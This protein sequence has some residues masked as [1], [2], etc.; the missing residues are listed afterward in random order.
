MMHPLLMSVALISSVA[1][2]ATPIVIDG[3]FDDWP[4]VAANELAVAEDGRFVYVHL[5]APGSPSN[6]QGLASPD[7][8]R[9][10][11]DHDEGTGA[12]SG[13]YRGTDLELH[14][15]PKTGRRS[16]GVQIQLPGLE[17]G[18]LDPDAV[19]L[20]FAPTAASNRFE[21]RIPRSIETP[22]GPVTVGGRVRLHR[23]G[24]FGTQ[25]QLLQAVQPRPQVEPAFQTLPTCPDS[26]IRVVS[27]NVEFGGLLEHPAPF[28]R[29]LAALKPHVIL[30]QELEP[31]Q[32]AGDI[33]ALLKAAVPG[34][35]TV[36]LGPVGGRLRSAVATRLS[37]TDLPELDTLKRRDSDDRG[38]RGAGLTVKNALSPDIG[39]VSLHLKCCGAA[40]GPEDMTRIAEVL[41]VRRAITEADHRA[42]LGGLIIGGD[43]NLVGSSLPLELLVDNGESMLGGSGDLIIAEAMRPAGGG[44]QTW[45]KDGQRYTPGRLDWIAATGSSLEIANAF[46]LA[47]DECSASVLSD[48]GMQPGD[49]AAASD[50]LPVVADFIV[51]SPMRLGR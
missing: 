18:W 12:R 43:L 7:V 49:S 42:P 25:G 15:S 14:F 50:H 13:P 41:A 37:A 39:V 38:V 28:Q 22:R 29:I 1:A 30:I 47:T 51:R 23:S 46:V 44:M 24:P 16:G 6:L 4:G 2:D 11:L 31:D 48:L 36:D 8:L 20:V 27:W 5:P 33:E 17:D 19:D 34:N 32:R 35:W 40:E 3:R 21:I 10:D 26:G 9:I 45:E